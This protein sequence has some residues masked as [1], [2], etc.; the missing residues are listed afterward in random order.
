MGDRGG[1]VVGEGDIQIQVDDGVGEPIAFGVGKAGSVLAAAN[2]PQAI[3]EQATNTIT[4]NLG[5][6]PIIRLE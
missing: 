6:F 2:I 3:T 1:V 5:S 4:S